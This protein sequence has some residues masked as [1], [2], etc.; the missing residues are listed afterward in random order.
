MFALSSLLLHFS[1]DER[2]TGAA[3]SNDVDSIRQFK[4]PSRAP[5]SNTFGGSFAHKRGEILSAASFE[6]MTG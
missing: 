3:I 5:R 2:Q 6:E 1:L 4:E